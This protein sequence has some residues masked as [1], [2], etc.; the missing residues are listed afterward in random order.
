M[1]F[2]SNEEDEKVAIQFACNV[3]KAITFFNFKVSGNFAPHKL[4]CQILDIHYKFDS[5]YQCSQPT[6]RSEPS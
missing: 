5:R 4:L 6:Q 3:T 2:L 1:W